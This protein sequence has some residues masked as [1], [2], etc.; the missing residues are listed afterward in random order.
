VA[1]GE[2]RSSTERPATPETNAAELIQFRYQEWKRERS[3]WHASDVLNSALVSGDVD[4]FSDVARF[5]VENSKTAPQ[6]LVDLSQRIL[7]PKVIAMPQS[8]EQSLNSTHHEIHDLRRRLVDEPR[9]SIV[10]SDLSRLYVSIGL[11]K[12]AEAAMRIAISIAPTNRFILRAAGRLFLHIKETKDALRLFRSNS[13]VVLSDPWLTAAEISISSAADSP[14][15]FAKKG[16]SIARNADFS[17]FSRAELRSALATLEMTN[18]KN[19]SARRF[20]QE[21]LNCPN[22]NSLAQ[23]EWAER[24]VG[25]ITIRRE[26]LEIPLSFEARAYDAYHREMW[27]EAFQNGVKWVADEHYSSR[28]FMFASYISSSILG[29]YSRSVDLLKQGLRGNPS[30]PGI[31]NNLAFAYASDNRLFEAEKAL[32][33]VDVDSVSDTQAITLTATQGLVLMRRGHLAEGRECYRKAYAA[34]VRLSLNRYRQLAAI[35]LAREELL[36]D[37]SEAKVAL[38]SAKKEVDKNA[39]TDVKVIFNRIF[40]VGEFKQTRR[41]V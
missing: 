33:G 13:D 27:E 5:V 12:K 1:L 37:T 4:A 25:G 31:L 21:S 9:N 28:P 20:F 11:D 34:S 7:S 35:Y 8:L 39:D 10:W 15:F 2:L 16:V 18:G 32:A 26:Q 19:R 3:I 41:I 38:E 24:Y 22:E 30:N 14:S 6:S 29:Q 40:E 17:D 23:V 36:A